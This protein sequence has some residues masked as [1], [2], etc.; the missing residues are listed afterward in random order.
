V[1]PVRFGGRI[2]HWDP[3]KGSGLAVVD[4]PPEDVAAMG[5]LRQ[6]RV[7]G[8]LGGAAFTS[9]VMPAGGGRLALSVSRAMMAAAR[10]GVGDEAEVVIEGSGAT[11]GRGVSSGGLRDPRRQLDR[12][13]P[14][15]G[16]VDRAAL[17]PRVEHR[18][19]LRLRMFP[20][21]TNGPRFLP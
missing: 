13:R 15:Q 8:T 2:R 10:I 16:E 20:W 11:D 5:G 19:G 21:R 17:A 9:S 3:A 12:A 18:P 1:E 6:H 7:H 4:V 14:Q